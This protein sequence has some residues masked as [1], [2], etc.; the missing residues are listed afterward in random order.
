MGM[1]THIIGFKPPNEKW[2]RMKAVWD[3][4]RAAGIDPPK[5][6]Y[7]F[8]EGEPPDASGIPVDLEDYNCTMHYREDGNEG[9]EVHVTK[10]PLDVTVIRFYNSW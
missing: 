4:C 5:E 8:F 10:L 9:Y 1:S 2:K 7:D 6:V 3:T